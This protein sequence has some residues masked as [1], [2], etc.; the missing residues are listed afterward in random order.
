MSAR[1]LADEIGFEAV[2]VGPLRN[3]RHLESLAGLAACLTTHDAGF[4]L[5]V[6]HHGN[7]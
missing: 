6:R 7:W 3:A 1:S 2:N 4:E 5:A